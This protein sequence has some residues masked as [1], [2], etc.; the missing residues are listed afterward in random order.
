M[1]DKSCPKNICFDGFVKEKYE[2]KF[3]VRKAMRRRSRSFKN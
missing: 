3:E 1:E 2:E